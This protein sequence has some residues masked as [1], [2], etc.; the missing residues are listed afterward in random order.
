MCS[1]LYCSCQL[2]MRN[3]FCDSG[4]SFAGVLD[5]GI[6]SFTK[7]FP[8]TSSLITNSPLIQWNEVAEQL[9]LIHCIQQS[10]NNLIMLAI[11]KDKILV[12]TFII[13]IGNRSC[14]LLNFR[15]PSS[16]SHEVNVQLCC[17]SVKC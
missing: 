9:G 17:S 6:K 12:I 16:L 1:L 10:N 2:G 8:I 7:I 11:K 13:T 3:S 15:T 4:K 14:L 5:N